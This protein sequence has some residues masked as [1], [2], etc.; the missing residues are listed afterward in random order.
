MISKFTSKGDGESI[1]II[2]ESIVLAKE[3]VNAKDNTRWTYVSL[4]N[5]HAV[6]IME[7]AKTVYDHMKK[8]I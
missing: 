5:G 7:S 6:E 1:Y 2:T 3:Y 4:V 8:V